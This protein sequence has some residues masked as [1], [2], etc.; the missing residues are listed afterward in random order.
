MESQ[1]ILSLNRLWQ[2]I[3]PLRGVRFLV[4][5]GTG[6]AVSRGSPSPGGRELE[7]GGN[8]PSPYSSPIKGG[9]FS[10]IDTPSARNDKEGRLKCH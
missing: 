4:L 1:L 6:S 9:D 2:S 5:L 8:S 7:G 3:V 10:E